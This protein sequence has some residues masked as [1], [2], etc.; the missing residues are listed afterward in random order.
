MAF[1]ATAAGQIE[2]P[3]KLDQ[4]G[5]GIVRPVIDDAVNTSDAYA[6]KIPER[7]FAEIGCHISP[8]GRSKRYL[9]LDLTISQKPAAK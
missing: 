6:G 4:I 9:R 3:L 8:C 5:K 2:L 1:G 7:I